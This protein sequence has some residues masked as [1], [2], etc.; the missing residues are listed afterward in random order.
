MNT[1]EQFQEAITV[2]L[3]KQPFYASLLL[4]MEREFS[5]RIP[6]AGVYVKNKIHLTINPEFFNSLTVLERVAVLMHECGHVINNHFARYKNFDPKLFNIAADIA[7][8]QLIPGIP[9][10]FTVKGE[11]CKT[12]TIQNYSQFKLVPNETTENYY[13]T[14]FKNAK[15]IT[16][17]VGGHGEGQPQD[18]QTLDDHEIWKEGSGNKTL[19]HNV[20]KNAVNNAYKQAIA[21][22]HGNIPAEVERLIQELNKS[23]LDWKSILRRFVANS[24]ECY[25]VDT[26]KRR[27]RRFGVYYPGSKVESKLN[28]VEINDTS[29][30]M[31]EE[32]L[33]EIYNELVGMARQQVKITSIDCDAKVHDV[34]KFDSRV[35]PK[36][37]GGGGTCMSPA[38]TEAMKHSPDCIIVFTD[39]YIPDPIKVSV[40]VLWVIT[41]ENKDFKVPYGKMVQM[42]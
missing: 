23:Q 27:N 5:D 35:K 28:V 30:S 31:S 41:G 15:K 17:K 34:R 33:S 42:S 21:R 14:L 11:K 38:L 12:A 6:T 20:V 8:N 24:S 18:G 26:R 3:L 13:A 39:G 37:K 36:F 29:G 9:Q 4:Q 1:R 25:V 22:Q 32:Q 2:L 7:I 16:I 40:P 10:E 19:V